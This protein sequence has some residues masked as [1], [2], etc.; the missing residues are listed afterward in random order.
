L[1]LGF[2]LSAFGFVRELLFRG[3]TPIFADQIFGLRPKSEYLGKSAGR[4]W[5]L[6]NSRGPASALGL[7]RQLLFRGCTPI[8]ADQILS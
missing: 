6:G 3:C 2:R 5:W 7:V 4:S 8:F 1:A